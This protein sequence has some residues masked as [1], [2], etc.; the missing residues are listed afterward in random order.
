MTE[1]SGSGDARRRLELL[2]GIQPKPRRGLAR[3]LVDAAQ[4]EQRTGLTDKQWV[5]ANAPMLERLIE[6]GRYPTITRFHYA[7]V[8]DAPIDHFEFGLRRLLDGVQAY[9]AASG[10]R[11]STQNAPQQKA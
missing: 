2:W 10:C 6:R 7:G 9:V 1:Y 4:V 3:A 5:T 11:R 8:F